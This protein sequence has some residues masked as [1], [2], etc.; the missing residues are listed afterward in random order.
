[1]NMAISSGV[2]AWLS[3]FF[4]I[5]SWG[6]IRVSGKRKTGQVSHTAS[7]KVYAIEFRD[8]VCLGRSL[9]SRSHAVHGVA[10]RKR[11]RARFHGLTIENEKDVETPYS[12][13]RDPH[14]AVKEWLC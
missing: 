12:M 1:M 8:R 11:Q 9:V 5:I 7:N 6:R 10:S 13:F 14:H 2:N 3:R 4:S